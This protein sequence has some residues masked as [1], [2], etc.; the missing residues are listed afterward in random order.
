M[1]KKKVIFLVLCLLVPFLIPNPVKS[2]QGMGANTLC[3]L[4]GAGSGTGGFY[5]CGEN[6]CTWKE[7]EDPLGEADEECDQSPQLF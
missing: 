6:G 1:K 5:L 2:F 7:G 3:W 4:S